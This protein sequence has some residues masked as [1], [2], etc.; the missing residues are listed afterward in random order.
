MCLIKNKNVQKIGGDNNGKIAGRDI[1]E[2]YNDNSKKVTIVQKFYNSTIE[3]AKKYYSEEYKN[4]VNS[5]KEL[6]GYLYSFIFSESS[7]KCQFSSNYLNFAK[8]LLEWIMGNS[9]FPEKEYKKYCEELIRIYK[10]DTD[11]VILKRWSAFEKYFTSDISGAVNIY[12]EIFKDIS[13]LKC[14][15]D[16]LDDIL[17]DGRNLLNEIEEL[18][19]KIIV[20]NPF[21]KELDK[22]NR[23][24]TMPVYDRLKADSY[25]KVLKDTFTIQTKNSNTI[26]FGS[27][28]ES[29]LNE[30]QNLIFNTVFYGSITHIKLCRKV[31]SN[32]M[33]SYS[34][35]HKNENF[36][37]ITLKMLALS[38]EYK[39]YEKLCLFLGEFQNFWCSSD[40]I[41]EILDL[42]N[43]NLDYKKINYLNFIYGF[44]GKYLNDKNYKE[45]E[46]K[47][48]EYLKNVDVININLALIM[49]KNIKININRTQNLEEILKIFEIFIKKGFS[50]FYHEISYILNCIDVKV[51]KPEIYKRYV[52]IVY[53]ISTT[54]KYVDL[55]FSIANILNKNKNARRFYKY[56]KNLAVKELISFE[57]EISENYT[58]FNK[59]IEDYEKWYKEK[60]EEP[61]VVIEH[62]VSYILS[63]NFF[64]QVFENKKIV[65]LIKDVYLPLA[66]RILES[67]KQTNTFKLEQLKNLLYL[68]S[69]GDYKFLK[70][71]INNII[72][73]INYGYGKES[74]FCNC[75]NYREIS[76]YEID[77][78]INLITLFLN[79][80]E[81][82][83][84]IIT[85]CYEDNFYNKIS[86]EL[87][88]NCLKIIGCSQKDNELILNQIYCFYIAV[89]EKDYT[90]KLKTIDLLSIFSDTKFERK[91]IELLEKY[92]LNCSFDIAKRILNIIREYDSR[93]I[94]NILTNLKV[95]KNF[96]VRIIAKNY[97]NKK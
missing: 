21:Q 52:K 96:N 45:I 30:I 72:S 71:N 34:K 6:E 81:N 56:K 8:A 82:F 51:L 27:G 43:R 84:D 41:E 10:I 13:N 33:Y 50:R 83:N 25:E 40:F 23:K 78:Y 28:L 97:E 32:V 53:Q 66:L 61:K 68:S 63:R 5:F 18:N 17:I 67:E 55:K 22:H 35:I 49:L 39:E 1:V 14:P 77:L 94:I 60:E 80:D 93:K 24:L 44:Y 31:I 85:Q 64:I 58:F 74:S 75:F 38:G 86:L 62:D 91:S 57:K 89:S 48:Y 69:I 90:N 73:K 19:N 9:N 79:K 15:C 95:H 29:V 26:I 20:D 11:D 37:K 12:N 70:E 65:N 42:K 16:L 3:E 7:E 88:S 36:Y 59:M 92:S 87:I 54:S 47:I 76:N 4:Y 46:E 2:Y